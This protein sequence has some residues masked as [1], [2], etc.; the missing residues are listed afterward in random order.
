MATATEPSALPGA[1]RLGILEARVL[2]ASHIS[3]MAPITGISTAVRGFG[4]GISALRG[5]SAALDFGVPFTLNQGVGE[6]DQI[7]VGAVGD[8]SDLADHASSFLRGDQR[9]SRA[10]QPAGVPRTRDASAIE[11]AERRVPSGSYLRA[12]RP[13]ITS[14]KSSK[15][16]PSPRI[17]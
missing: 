1:T 9:C 6:G 10:Q 14:L 8:E 17:A 13:D 7:G 5:S 12:T 16:R 11:G 4:T 3:A 15:D 2:L